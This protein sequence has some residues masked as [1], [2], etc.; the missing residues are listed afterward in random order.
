MDEVSHETIRSAMRDVE[1]ELPEYYDWGGIAEA[2]LIAAAKEA[3]RYLLRNIR[4]LRVFIENPDSIPNQS[5]GYLRAQKRSYRESQIALLALAWLR[6][7]ANEPYSEEREKKR[8]KA[9]GKLW[10]YRRILAL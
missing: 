5:E 3:E 7:C 6:Q 8:T 1:G 10:E 4:A 9:V 2:C